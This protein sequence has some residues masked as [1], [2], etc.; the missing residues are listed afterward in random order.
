MTSS[1]AQRIGAILGAFDGVRAVYLFG[2]AAEDRE[3]A[4]SDVDLAVVPR[5]GCVRG[6]RVEMLAALAGAG[7]YVSRLAKWW[8]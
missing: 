4:D 8:A 2:S 5:D 3:R 1:D 7:F 6:Q